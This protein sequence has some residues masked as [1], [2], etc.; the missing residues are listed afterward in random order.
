MK[1]NK[2]LSLFLLLI[3]VLN[4]QTFSSERPKI[5][6]VLSGGGA[7]GFA[8]IGVLKVLEKNGIRP[9]FVVGTSIGGLIGG[10][11]SIGYSPD[12]LE[13]L[14]L[15]LKWDEYLSDDFPR[16]YTYIY[17]K[18]EQ[19]R[20]LLSFLIDSKTGIKLPA[21][22]IQGQNIMNLL[23]RLTGKYHAAKD[24]SKLPIPFKCVACNIAT[25]EEV[26][27]DSGFLPEALFATM[28]IPTVFAPMNIDN[29]LLVDGGI[30]N[31][32]AVDVAKKMGADFV[33]GVDIQSK[34]LAQNDIKDFADVAGQLTTLLGN[35]KYLENKQNCDILISPDISSFG[36]SDF[37][38]ESAKI[39]IARGQLAAMSM[40]D[41][42]KI[43]FEANHIPLDTSYSEYEFKNHFNI[44]NVIAY[45]VGSTSLNYIL[46]KTNFNFPGSYDFD[47]INEGIRKLYGTNTYKI[48]YFKLL[49]EQDKI[50]ELKVREK[51]TDYVNA[52]FAYNSLDK[53]SILINLT[54]RNQ[55]FGG[56]RF[57]LDFIIAKTTSVKG[58]FQFIQTGL[59]ELNLEAEYR[60]VDFEIFNKKDKISD[61]D[62]NYFRGDI[63]T[64]SSIGN[65]YLMGIG[66]RFERF[67]IST[68]F[69]T[70]YK[71]EI[72]DK[73]K[74]N[75]FTLYA[76]IKFDN[77]DDKYLPK[78]GSKI[79]LEYDYSANKFNDL[80]NS[81]K[82][83]VLLFTLKSA[84]RLG[85]DV[86]F[87]PG[88]YGRFLL[89]E[90]QE[91]ILSN[92][93]G[94]EKS[95]QN[96]YYNL[97]FMGLNRGTLVKD[98]VAIADL[99]MRL[100]LTDNQYIST[101]FDVGTSFTYFRDWQSKE[102]FYGWGLKY[103]YV[104]L[105]GPIEFCVS[106]SDYSN[107]FEF[108]VSVGKW[109]NNL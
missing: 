89:D 83:S 93:I 96:F 69:S 73:L 56:A 4:I 105:I 52:G 30:V 3:I 104:S 68:F 18:E 66:G 77:L 94:G 26:V 32:F 20:Y 53:A 38:R 14:V 109:F 37:S 97:P 100:R 28:A 62:I 24:F 31:N 72:E 90:N 84:I 49:D 79:L 15:T 85:S 78:S 71:N 60:Q 36:T 51:P 2:V 82:T 91:T 47:R 76:K 88:I 10:L 61:N 35:D 63:S 6:L 81:A 55:M 99:A 29:K 54:L 19:D 107:D 74:K 92:F 50:L 65:N 59:P 40:V 80:F 98:K 17:E 41:S 87:L 11:Y 106:T 102:L 13:E 67:D 7:K 27:L 33:I 39:L 58:S 5:A 48:I 101:I 45:G 70:T 25:G 9:D 23:C 8:H 21:G 12:Q 57:S 16:E 22:F 42:I 43:I 44:N 108:F 34:L 103:T 75:F 1:K 95:V 64:L 86:H 46:E